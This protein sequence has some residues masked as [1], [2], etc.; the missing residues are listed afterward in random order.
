MLNSGETLI[1]ECTNELNKEKQYAVSL[2]VIG[3]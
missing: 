3:G 1:G 2:L